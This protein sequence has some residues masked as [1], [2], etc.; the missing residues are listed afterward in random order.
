MIDQNNLSIAALLEKKNRKR[1]CIYCIYIYIYIYT[2]QSF[3]LLNF[4]ILY[5]EF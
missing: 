4:V 1:N 5:R 3:E 2:S